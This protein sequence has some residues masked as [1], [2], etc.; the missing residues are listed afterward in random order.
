LVP[1]GW[2]QQT[3]LIA[4]DA[5]AAAVWWRWFSVDTVRRAAEKYAERLFLALLP[6]RTRPAH[7]SREMR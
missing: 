2:K 5:A 7:A 1:L 4:F 3:A 6:V